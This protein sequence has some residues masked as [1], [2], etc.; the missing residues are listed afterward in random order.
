MVVLHVKCVVSALRDTIDELQLE[1][2]RE[3]DSALIQH[4]CRGRRIGQRREVLVS[5]AVLPQNEDYETWREGDGEEGEAEAENQEEHP[6]QNVV[7][8]GIMPN[9]SVGWFVCRHLEWKWREDC[10]GRQARIVMR[11]L[12]GCC[13]NE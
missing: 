8:Q 5:R 6:L 1:L 9:R 7:Q 2:G 3:Q 11:P 4:L 13:V 10:F 12:I